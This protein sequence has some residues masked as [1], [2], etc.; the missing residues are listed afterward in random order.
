[1]N[2]KKMFYFILFLIVLGIIFYFVSPKCGLKTD[3][4]PADSQI[5]AIIED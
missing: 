4:D 2:N 5:E 3:V 1:M